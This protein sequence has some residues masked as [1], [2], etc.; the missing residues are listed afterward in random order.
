MVYFHTV[1]EVASHD[2]EAKLEVLRKC[3]TN[4]AY[5]LCTNVLKRKGC[6]VL[7]ICLVFIILTFI[8]SHMGICSCFT[9]QLH[10]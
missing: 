10:M 6:C 8:I 5:N 9:V 7:P 3:S 2:V 1:F 4:A